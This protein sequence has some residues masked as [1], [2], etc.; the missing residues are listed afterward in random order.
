M[1]S[2]GILRGHSD[3][4]PHNI[5]Q[6]CHSKPQPLTQSSNPDHPHLTHAVTMAVTL[7]QLQSMVLQPYRWLPS[8]QPA[9]RA[10]PM[11]CFEYFS[12]RCFVDSVLWMWH[13]A[14]TGIAVSIRS[15]RLVLF[16]PFCNT[17]YTNSWSD[18]ARSM[19]PQVG[20]SADRW[21]ANGWTLCGDAVSP[22]AWGDQGICAIQHMVCTACNEGIMSDCD[23][24]INKRDSACV[25]LDQCDAMNPLDAYQHPQQGRPPLLP[26]LSLY[27]GD[28]FA[29]VAMPLPTDWQRIQGCCFH[30]QRPTD[31]HKAPRPVDWQ[32][33]RDCAVF[34]GGTTGAGGNR[35]TNQRI[36]LLHHHDSINMDFKGT[37]LNQRLRYCPIEKQIVR[38]WADRTLDIGRHNYVPLHKQQELYKFIV[39][40]DGHSGAD[41]L[42]A[43]M[44]GNQVILKIASPHHALCPDTWASQRMYAWQH[45]VPVR[46]DM[47]D[48]RD[49][50]QWSRQ[51]ETACDDMRRQCMVWTKHERLRVLQWWVDASAAMSR[52]A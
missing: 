39:S 49:K 41:R 51:H 46:A 28:Q 34:R 6:P 26:V 20:L 13:N 27:T 36:A 9:A 22:Q 24:I 29:D 38:P 32:S 19:L 7:D 45:Y 25:R 43:L 37:S 40:A 5:S 35:H 30:A 3:E 16:V 50:L 11:Q 44:E 42:G 10:A 8:L 18:K 17:E 33:K 12:N 47:R 31:L 48:I 23:F 52:L 21:W 2:G 15:G 4:C 14:R 1:W